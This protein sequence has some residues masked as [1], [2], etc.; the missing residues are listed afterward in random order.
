MTKYLVKISSILIYGIPFLIISGPFL[1]DLALII[2]CTSFLII[3]FR[4]KLFHLYKNK[5]FQIFFYFYVYL[6]IRS[7]FTQDLVS[8][9]SSFFY[10]RFGLFALAFYYF[11]LKNYID[12]KKLFF[13]ILFTLSIIF[14]DSLIQYYTG[15]NILGFET[16][17]P[18]RIS[19]FFYDELILGSFSFRFLI[20][21]IPL[22]FIY[23]KKK[24]YPFILLIIIATLIFLSGERSALALIIIFTVYYL[25][26]TTEKIKYFLT[27]ILILLS[28]F[29]ILLSTSDTIYKRIITVTKNNFYINKEEK[30]I[31]FSQVHYQHYS[32]GYKMFKENILFGVGPKMFRFKCS[33]DNYNSGQF[34]CSTHPH[35]III[36]FLAEF[37][38]LGFIFLCYFYYVLIKNLLNFKLY[39]NKDKERSFL[40][41]NLIVILNFFP[42][43][44]YGNFLNN[45]L[46]I[47]NIFS[48]SLLGYFKN[49]RLKFS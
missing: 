22:Y 21:I 13:V 4:E 28:L 42:F 18:N 3:S 17:H 25:F 31:A 44:P 32:T 39:V 30:I 11:L 35:N 2:V 48:I 24:V 41:L 9:K 33:D 38:L 12:L 20:I 10:I 47:F 5:Y 8:I 6:L 37:G 43:L 34:S 7:L 14:I 45:W 36:Q 26:I 23:Y 49:G 1:S 29:T 46:S 15:F 19:S 40:I 16:L 27:N